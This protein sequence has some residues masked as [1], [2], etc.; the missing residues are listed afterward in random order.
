VPQ[1]TQHKDKSDGT[2]LLNI[3]AIETNV[4]AHARITFAHIMID[5]DIW[6][7]GRDD[8]H[9]PR[10]KPCKA[11]PNPVFTAPSNFRWSNEMSDK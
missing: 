2:H 3:M 9:R 10:K 6:A 11:Y 4:N 1:D 8:C 7:P 5:S